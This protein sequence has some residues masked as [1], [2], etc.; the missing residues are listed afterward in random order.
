MLWLRDECLQPFQRTPRMCLTWY[1]TMLLTR[2]AVCLVLFHRCE[3]LL[4]SVAWSQRQV[5]ANCIKYLCRILGIGTYRNLFFFK[6]LSNIYKGDQRCTNKSFFVKGNFCRASAC[7][8]N[9]EDK[10]TSLGV[11][12]AMKFGSVKKYDIW[13]QMEEYDDQIVRVDKPASMTHS[14]NKTL[15]IS[16]FLQPSWQIGTH[17][18]H[19]KT[20]GNRETSALWQT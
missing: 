3:W 5:H 1:D 7:N 17:R 11:I 9:G 19:Q 4:I 16:S 2:W 8:R 10:G 20:P 13:F 15:H 14:F 12:T 18:S 6:G